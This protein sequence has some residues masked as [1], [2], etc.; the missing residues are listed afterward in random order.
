MKYA[1]FYDIFVYGNY[2][3]TKWKGSFT[4]K[5][6][7]CNAYNYL[8]DFEYS[9]AKGTVVS[10]I[11]ELVD[12]LLDGWYSTEANSYEDFKLSDWLRGLFLELRIRDEKYEQW[13]SEKE[14]RLDKVVRNE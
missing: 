10:T 4:Q 7:A 6:I 13:A 5:E 12:L 11:R 3:N 14:K 2:E 8:V 9:K 1:D